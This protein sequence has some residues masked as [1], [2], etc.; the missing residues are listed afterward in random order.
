MDLNQIFS[1][2]DYGWAQTM[3]G[4]QNGVWNFFFK[5]FSYLSDKGILIFIIALILIL[6]K[7][8]RYFGANMF[9]C[10]GVAFFLSLIAKYMVDRPRPFADSGSDLYNWWVAAGSAS[11]SNTGSFPSG[12]ATVAFAFATAFLL[13]AD[14]RYGWTGYLFAVL[15]AVGRTYLM[16]HYLSDVIFGAVFG[17]VG[18]VLG[19]LVTKLIFD[20]LNNHKENK[21]CDF[22]LNAD[23]RDL[24]KKK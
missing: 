20:I 14:R 16:V 21:F 12:H 22:C 23:V 2:M 6:F 3:H 10:V 9:I 7:K 13:T 11:A 8:T 4:S 19:Y 24:I 17:I 1:G 5:Y 15:T 18:A